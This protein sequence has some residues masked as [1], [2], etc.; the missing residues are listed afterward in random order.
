[1][2]ATVLQTYTTETSSAGIGLAVLFMLAISLCFTLVMLGSLWKLFQKMGDPGWMGII[3][4]FNYYRIFQ[5]TRPEQAILWTLLTLVCGV[6]VIVAMLDIAKLF[7]R[8]NNIVFVLGLIFF[9]FIF[10]PILAFGGAQY[11]GPPAPQLS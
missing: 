10:L 2:L 11:Q 8:D 3:P 7:G 4:V 1:M 6:G 9:P 5:R